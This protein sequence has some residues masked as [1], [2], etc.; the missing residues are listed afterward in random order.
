MAQGALPV[1]HSTLSTQP[2]ENGK[3]I[4]GKYKKSVWD[5]LRSTTP[6]PH[7]LLQCQEILDAWTLITVP[8]SSLTISGGTRWRP[9]MHKYLLCS[10]ANPQK[11]HYLNSGSTGF[12]APLG[13]R[14]GQEVGWQYLPRY[15][16]KRGSINAITAFS[17]NIFFPTPMCITQPCS[18]KRIFR[19][20]KFL[21]GTWK[22]QMAQLKSINPDLFLS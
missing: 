6:F 13:W 7:I 10:V 4:K 1:L 5:G 22:S 12:M 21:G 15:L 17:I 16:A 18:C 3:T 19:N 20:E 9:A 2:R 14:G 8:S 11:L